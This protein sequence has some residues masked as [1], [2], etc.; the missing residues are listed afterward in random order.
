MGGGGGNVLAS[1]F[2]SILR[3]VSVG[4]VAGV[5]RGVLPGVSCNCSP[6]GSSLK[7]C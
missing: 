4:V 7:S 5:V 2:V 3:G 6:V 1:R